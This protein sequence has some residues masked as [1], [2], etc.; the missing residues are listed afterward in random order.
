MAEATVLPPTPA[1]LDLSR[2]LSQVISRFLQ[3]R[4]TIRK[5]GEY[6]ADREGLVLMYLVIRY[7]EGVIALANRPCVV[8]LR[9][10]AHTVSI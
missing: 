1:I 4:K 3:A 10:G 5:L 8:A 2:L 9:H 7:V 6:E